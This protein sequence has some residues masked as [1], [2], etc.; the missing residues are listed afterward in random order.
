MVKKA[1]RAAAKQLRVTDGGK[2]K[3]ATLEDLIRLS[4][5]VQQKLKK[6]G[7]GVRFYLESGPVAANE[8]AQTR[9]AAKI[10]PAID[11]RPR[12]VN[13]DSDGKPTKDG[14]WIFDRTTGLVW[15]R[16][17]LA[18]EFTY[19][20]ALKACEKEKFRGVAARAP[21]LQERF[22]ITD[23]D[24]HSPALDTAHFAKDTGWEWTSTLYASSPRG[25]AWFV[26]LGFGYCSW[27]S[28]GGRGPVRPVLAGQPF[29]FD[30]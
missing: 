3:P 23:Y 9:V 10:V 21:T 30:F 4:V 13:L 6:D 16:S 15:A 24:K 17:V 5:G 12:F 26:S 2:A 22:S 7:I 8:E 28:Q 14:S 19:A 11:T 25:F 1:T 29:N 18:G 27:G 20:D